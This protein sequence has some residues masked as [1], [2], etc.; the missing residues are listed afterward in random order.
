LFIKIRVVRYYYCYYYFSN[1]K[2]K[3]QNKNEALIDYIVCLILDLLGLIQQGSRHD[4]GKFD[5]LERRRIEFF[6]QS[7][8][9]L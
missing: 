3:K 8:N 7:I 2:K 5:I 4:I 1:L 6:Y 9:I